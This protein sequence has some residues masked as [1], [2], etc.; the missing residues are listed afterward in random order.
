MSGLELEARA[1]NL[2]TAL[3]EAREA[4]LNDPMIAAFHNH[5]PE[6]LADDCVVCVADAA[7]AP[8]PGQQT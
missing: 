5:H 7:L 1:R 2:E 8:Q 6:P 4:L 3:H